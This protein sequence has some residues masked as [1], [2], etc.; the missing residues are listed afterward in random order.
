MSNDTRINEQV[1]RILARFWVDASELRSTCTRGTLRFHGTL[2]R[3]PAADRECP[4]QEPVIEVLT[5]EIRRLPGVK[6]VYFTGVQVEERWV[7]AEL[8]D[9]DRNRSASSPEPQEETETVE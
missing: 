1:R 9:D 6:K 2:R 3:L 8:I 7:T 5:Q 4:L